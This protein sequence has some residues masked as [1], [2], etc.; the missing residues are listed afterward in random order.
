MVPPPAG[1]HDEVSEPAIGAPIVVGSTTASVTQLLAVASALGAVERNRHRVGGDRVVVELEPGQGSAGPA[2]VRALR[3]EGYA[4][5][6]GPLTPGHAV[7]WARRNAPV[8]F[9]A[10]ACVCFPWSAFDRDRFALVVEI[11][12]GAG[13]GSG[14]HPS[15][16]LLLRRLHAMDLSGCRLLDVGCGTGV[17][18]IAALLLGADRVV[19]VDIDDAARAAAA[20]N[21]RRNG[22]EDRLE[23][24]DAPLVRLDGTFD[25]I[26]ANIHAHVVESMAPELRRLTGDGLLALSGLSPAQPS[27]LVA[28]LA[29]MELIWTDESADWVAVGLGWSG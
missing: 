19:A 11:D 2:V 29:P 26:V 10:D 7:A 13:F 23:I 16:Q 5:I 22:V 24:T 12:P 28:A 4:A 1:R 8:R 25:V 9:A 14:G 18:A 21:G 15:T 6:D 20:A 27:T 3:T 17:L